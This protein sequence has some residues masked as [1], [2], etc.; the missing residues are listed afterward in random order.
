MKAK[1]K[2]DE[3]HQ[4]TR[5]NEGSTNFV[6]AP[7]E[8]NLEERIRQRAYELSQKREGEGGD[9]LRDWYQ[10]EAELRAAFGSDEFNRESGR[11]RGA[12]A[13]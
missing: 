12:Y 10:A 2:T 5:T 8:P 3:L 13:S 11:A 7:V 9:A 6:N 4:Q 1:T